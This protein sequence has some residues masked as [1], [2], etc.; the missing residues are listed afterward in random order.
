MG[1]YLFLPVL[2]IQ[3]A[4]DQY[5]YQIAKMLGYAGRLEDKR[6]LLTFLKK[7][8]PPQILIE[9]QRK[10]AKEFQKVSS[11]FFRLIFQNYL[12]IFLQTTNSLKKIEHSSNHSN[13]N[14]Q[15]YFGQRRH[16]TRTTNQHDSFNISN[17]THGRIL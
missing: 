9:C 3:E 12:Y 17:T 11:L 5:A 8:Q 4:N 15:P 13:R 14:F 6:S 10:C 1:G 2:P 16:F 7:I